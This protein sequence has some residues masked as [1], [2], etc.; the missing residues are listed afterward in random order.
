ME[1]YELCVF[2]GWCELTNYKVVKVT[3]FGG[4]VEDN[5]QIVEEYQKPNENVLHK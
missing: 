1:F 4:Q 3:T 2:C 5:N